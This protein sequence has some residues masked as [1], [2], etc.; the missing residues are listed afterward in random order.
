MGPTLL[1]LKNTPSRPIIVLGFHASRLS[2]HDVDLIGFHARLSQDSR[3]LVAHQRHMAASTP[4]LRL[5]HATQQWFGR[6][7]T[8]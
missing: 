2:R 4:D 3:R 7:R 6:V 1:T 8:T 5:L